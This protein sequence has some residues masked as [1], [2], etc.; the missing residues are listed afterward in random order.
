MT[1]K[2]LF[3]I[4]EISSKCPQVG[5]KKEEKTLNYVMYVFFLKVR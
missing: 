4:P 3:L 1:V 5:G 2:I